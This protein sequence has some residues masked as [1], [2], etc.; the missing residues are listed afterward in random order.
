VGIQGEVLIG[1]G[2]YVEKQMRPARTL[3]LGYTNACRCYLP[4]SKELARGGYEQSSYL[5]GGWTGPFRKGIEKVI[6]A[7]AWRGR[8]G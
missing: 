1:L 3:L 8:D 2:E 5:Y 6:A 7:A 4:D